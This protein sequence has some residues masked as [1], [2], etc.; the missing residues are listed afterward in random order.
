MNRTSSDPR[1][2]PFRSLV[3][4]KGPTPVSLLGAESLSDRILPDL[5]FKSSSRHQSSID[6]RILG[7]RSESVDA[8]PS[9]SVNCSRTL[10]GTNP[11][12]TD[13][14]KSSLL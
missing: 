12:T 3:R 1:E 7:C 2:D 8:P 13:D 14:T 6:R 11:V 4:L 10:F 5:R 9:T